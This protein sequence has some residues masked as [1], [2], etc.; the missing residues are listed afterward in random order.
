MLNVEEDMKQ[1][2]LND[3]FSFTGKGLHTGLTIT[4]TFKPAP[5]N[6]GVRLCRVDLPDQPCYEA[7]ADYVSATERGT[8]L[9]KGDWKISTVEHAL[10]ALYA[11]GVDNCLIEIDAP[12]MPILD[13]SAKYYVEAI[14]R[15]GLQEQIAEQKVFVVRHKMEYD[16]G[17]GS[18]IVILPDDEYSID[19]HI[20]FPSPVLTNQ[21]A[22]IE[23]WDEFASQIA[24][25][26]T[27]CFVREIHPLLDMGL[28]KGGDLENAVVIYDKEMPQQD[29]DNMLVQL[30]Q[31]AHFDATR[32]GYLCTLNYDNE[33]ARHK[34]LDVIGDLSLIGCRIRGKVIATCPGHGVNT[35]FCRQLRKEMRRTEQLPVIDWDKKP[36]LDTQ[37]IMN[38]LPHRYPMLLVDRVMQITKNTIVGIKNLTH[39]EMFF[40]GH[41][42]NEPVMPGVLMLEAL[43]QCGGLLA[44]H[45][46]KADE[47]YS[48]YLLKINNAK[49]RHKVKPGDV[50]ILKLE[51]LEHNHRGIITMQGY[52]F[53]GDQVA[54]EAELTA[55]V[56]KN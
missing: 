39:N 23:N 54:A 38:L 17:R 48:T 7:V 25:A 35:T 51:V 24:P 50:L 45:D 32:L 19:V 21:F 12:E 42:P 9:E 43:A 22:S 41:F 47:H 6:S 5:E 40:Q 46:K 28:I 53:V 33:P 55:Q 26:R 8:V 52:C 29:L 3:S 2:T 27:F 10:S 11:M 36:V 4:A 16:N 49:F 56:I 13:G 44:L 20:S 1:H 15:V 34:L 30:G 37:A 31:K 18:R 14:K